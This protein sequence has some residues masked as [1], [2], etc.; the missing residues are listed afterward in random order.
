M[1]AR[2]GGVGF[3]RFA[4][5]RGIPWE[6][7]PFNGW[8]E[9]A[10]VVVKEV[11]SVAGLWVAHLPDHLAAQRARH[12]KRLAAVLPKHAANAVRVYEPRDVRLHRGFG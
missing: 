8:R 10:R 1:A 5:V 4:F 7:H 6:D 3:A 11:G 12:V 9:R 2:G